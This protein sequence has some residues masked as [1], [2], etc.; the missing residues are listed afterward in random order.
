MWYIMKSADIVAN[1]CWFNLG[2]VTRAEDILCRNHRT[3]NNGNPWTCSWHS[4]NIHLENHVA[5]NFRDAIGNN[6]NT[7]C[8]NR[9]FGGREEE[10]YINW[11]N[12]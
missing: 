2:D 12:T 5:F 10:V 8:P 1:E 9:C 3:Q 7:S 11:N 4:G 6:N